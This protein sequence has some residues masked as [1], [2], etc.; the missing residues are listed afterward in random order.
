MVLRDTVAGMTSQNTINNRSK[1]TKAVTV[2]G[3][4]IM[5]S[6]AC[7]AAPERTVLTEYTLFERE[8][9]ERDVPEVD[10]AEAALTDLEDHYFRHLGV[11]GS[12]DF[13]MARTDHEDTTTQGLCFMAVD[14]VDDTEDSTCVGPDALE[15]GDLTDMVVHLDTSSG[16]GPSDAFLVPDDARFDDMPEGWSH[17]RNNVVVVTDPQSAPEGVEGQIPSGQDTWDE[18]TLQRDSS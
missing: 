4:G 12:T 2:L 7:Q 5:A 18:F 17:I 1:A 8:P 6:T 13:Y 3:L 16:D 14:S 9:S 11:H 15:G 10:M